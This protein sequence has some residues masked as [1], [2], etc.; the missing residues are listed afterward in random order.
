M[1]G[2]SQHER[3]NINVGDRVV[4]R[5]SDGIAYTGVIVEVQKESFN[6]KIV[7]LLVF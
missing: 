4:A 7:D 3:M 5:T 1:N 6:S 2:A